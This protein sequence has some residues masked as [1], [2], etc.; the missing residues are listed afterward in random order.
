MN[1]PYLYHPHPSLAA[2]VD[3]ICFYIRQRPE[4][5]EEFGKGKM[6]GVLLCADGTILKA[7]S[8]NAAIKDEEHYFVPPVYDLTHP[9]S[10]YLSDDDAISAI[11]RRLLE[12]GLSPDEVRQLT[13]RRKQLSQDLQLKIFTHFD[14]AD[15]QGGYK[16]IVDI[17]R[18]AGRGLPPGGAGEC[19]APRLL[20]FAR[21]HHLSPV[22]LAEFWYG[23]SPRAILRVHRQF[24]P[25]C[26]EKCSPILTYM[27]RPAEK[28]NIGSEEV[29]RKEKSWKEGGKK[30]ES[31]KK[32]E[33]WK[34]ESNK[35]KEG[36]E[37]V[38]RLKGKE[39]LESSKEEIKVKE[40]GEGEGEGGEGVKSKKEGKAGLFPTI[41]FEDEH[42]IVLSKPS[43]LLST[44]GKDASQPDVE[45]WLHRQYPEVK[46]PMLAHRLDQATSGLLLAAKDA[47]THRLLQQGFE[48][49][50]VHKRYVAWL[51][52]TL[53]SDCGLLSIPICPNPDDRPRQVT[54]W[55]FGKAA[56]TRYNVLKREG[57]RTLVEF[58]PLTGRT[59][60]LRLHAASPFGLDCPIVGD[61]L[62]NGH[63]A[64]SNLATGSN[65][66]SGSDPATGGDPATGS[67]NRLLLHA[68]DIKLELREGIPLEFHDPAGFE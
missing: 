57:G 53:K 1:N 67:D 10:F 56:Q 25:S 64:G 50:T 63:C 21:E 68:T 61:R 20:Q 46:G 60:Q 51:D 16:N 65:P 34:E 31:C 3:D 54:D 39:A 28:A 36:K 6:L 52:G 42:L 14:F 18:D 38:K 4:W 11:N 15:T 62:Y 41:L 37:E 44:P 35:D 24:Y 2:V 45:S 48:R 9:D 30:E 49:R 13:E 8:G 29:K 22:A 33:S 23:R 19:A 47:Q 26:I 7:Y 12:P 32:E 27:M 43:G 55:Q 5:D 66:A 58:F 40:G 59:H 17:F